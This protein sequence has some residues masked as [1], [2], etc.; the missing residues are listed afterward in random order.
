MN[1]I[2]KL[3]SPILL[4]FAVN[5]F[6]I[7]TPPTLS[8]VLQI[9]QIKQKDKNNQDITFELRS[10]TQL[11]E[12]TYRYLENAFTS[13]YKK[14]TFNTAITDS[15]FKD[16]FY[17]EIYSLPLIASNERGIQMEVFGHFTDAADQY[18]N[19]MSAD[20][21]LHEHIVNSAQSRG[22]NTDLS[23]GAG[24][25]FKTSQSSKIKVILSNKELPCYG[26]STAIVGFEKDF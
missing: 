25:S 8:N 13:F 19:N 16:N 20:N 1:L 18:L 9:Q 21:A 10:T 24:F 6:A 4:G 5:C 14:L 23:L 26:N 22:Y 15:T 7:Q 3:I 11:P 17:S 2:L 12:M